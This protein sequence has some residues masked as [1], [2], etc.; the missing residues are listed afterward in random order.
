M[1]QVI[2]LCHANL[3]IYLKFVSTNRTRLTLLF[4]LLAR[5]ELDLLDIA[6]DVLSD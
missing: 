1:V 4:V 5:F 2:A 6:F 3:L